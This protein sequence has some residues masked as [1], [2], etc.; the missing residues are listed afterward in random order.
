MRPFIIRLSRFFAYT[1]IGAA[2]AFVSLLVCLL[3]LSC[4]SGPPE[5]SEL[6]FAYPPGPLTLDPARCTTDLDRTLCALVYSGIVRRRLDGSLTPE[7]GLP[8]YP[9]R[10]VD[11]FEWIQ[12]D[13]SS[14]CASSNGLVFRFRVDP[15]AQFA[16]GR[17][18]FVQDI[19]YSFER[20]ADPETESAHTELVNPLLGAM[21]FIAA[22]RDR[23][24]GRSPDPIAVDSIL[25]I[26]ELGPKTFQLTMTSPN[27]SYMTRL[28]LP[29]MRILPA[30]ETA[31]AIRAA[32][33]PFALAS[34]GSGLW[35]VESVDPDE[36]VVLRCKQDH[37]SGMSPKTERLRFK[38]VEDPQQ[39]RTMFASELLALLE[40][41]ANVR[42]DYM[43][44]ATYHDQILAAS[45]PSTAFLAFNFRNSFFRDVRVR[46]T[47]REALDP[48][49]IAETVGLYHVSPA[50]AA[51]PACVYPVEDAGLE[52]SVVPVDKADPS[53][54]PALSITVSNDPLLRQTAEQIQSI[55][56]QNG[57]EISIRILD[58]T[59]HRKALDE[60]DFNL[61]LATLSGNVPDDFLTPFLLSEARSGGANFSRYANT[62]FDRLLRDARCQPDREKRNRMY[63][64]ADE[65]LRKDCGGVFLWHPLD[66]YV[67]QMWLSGLR[68]SPFPTSSVWNNLFRETN[69]KRYERREDLR[70]KPAP[71]RS[72]IESLTVSDAAILGFVQ[73]LTEFLPIS[74]SGHLKIA[75]RLFGLEGGSRFLFFD[76]LLHMGTL[77]AVVVFFFQDVKTLSKSLL[78]TPKVIYSTYQQ[79]KELNKTENAKKKKKRRKKK[80]ENKIQLPEEIMYLGYLAVGT[81][82]TG[83]FGLVFQDL[84]EFLFDSLHAVGFALVITGLL[85]LSTQVVHRREETKLNAKRAAIIG[86]AQG[87]AITPG[88]SRSGTTIATSLLLGLSR[89]TAVRFS[90]LLSIPA[91]AGATL[92]QAMDA[93]RRIAML[94]ALAGTGVSF[95]SGLL[96][97]WFLVLIVRKGGLFLFAMYTIP[98]GIFV[99]LVAG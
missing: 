55:L 76:C 97:L 38:I 20:L 56:V 67:R 93:T 57:L 47:I 49:H 53:N 60:G 85:L 37:W 16:N 3:S 28:A 71:P 46:Q 8:P 59:E 77:L 12:M 94:P 95:L 45:G 90:F 58:P 22:R 86:L 91:I 26:E 7:L 34:N 24:G 87:I 88:L 61:A 6:V 23:Y 36:E 79:N 82:V 39:A 4:G 62:Y 63:Q 30:T 65:L 42:S 92:L 40:P 17:E 98:L 75:Q 48:H 9:E 78:D 14:Q 21:D 74:S 32:T 50:H 84:L 83:A 35:E 18:V 52:E 44:D 1:S 41:P 2:V 66:V 27:A 25:G 43:G 31:N 15:D 13:L 5:G 68:Y 64:Q 96:F 72:S 99:F 54:W 33:D 89:E 10:G 80:Q 51:V 69:E 73:G 11:P 29:S 70:V 19:R 81:F